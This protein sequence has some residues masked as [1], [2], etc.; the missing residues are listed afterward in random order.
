M[1]WLLIPGAV[2]LWMM[3]KRAVDRARLDARFR[4]PMLRAPRDA[5]AAPS[6]QLLLP[7][8]PSSRANA[9]NYDQHLAT[10]MM[11]AQHLDTLKPLAQA[12]DV[13]GLM[14]AGS[15]ST[16]DTLSENMDTLTIQKDL[17]LL[18]ASPP[19]V[20]DGVRGDVTITAIQDFQ[21]NFNLPATGAVDGPTAVALRYS[22]GIIASQN[23]QAQVGY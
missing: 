18:G 5:F 21:R 17:N 9:E 23:A 8:P 1:F 4:G 20:E 15:A 7:P 3:H 16:L 12:G 14:N 2:V 13:S 10:A 6:S 11:A 22:V 19:L